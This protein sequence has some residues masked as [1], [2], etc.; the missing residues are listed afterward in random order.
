MLILIWSHELSSPIQFQIIR[1]FISY[2][3]AVGF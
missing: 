1:K 2:M 3:K